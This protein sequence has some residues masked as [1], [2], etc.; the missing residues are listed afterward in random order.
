MSDPQRLEA[1]EIK[2]AHLELAL[3]ELGSTVMDQQRQIS[4]L[5]MRNRE[6]LQ[7]LEEV[8][9][10]ALPRNDRFEKPPHY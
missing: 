6:L 2:I 1:L 3:Q 10:A 5:A 9:E 4:A 7:Q 8:S